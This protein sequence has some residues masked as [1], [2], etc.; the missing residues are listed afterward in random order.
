MSSTNQ[1][2]DEANT[3]GSTGGTPKKT[4]GRPRKSKAESGDSE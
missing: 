1:K 3:A 2:K 4:K